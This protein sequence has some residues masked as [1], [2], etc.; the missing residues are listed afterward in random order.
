MPQLL[1]AKVVLT[2]DQAERSEQRGTASKWQ[3]VMSMEV[4]RRGCW[5]S[6]KQAYEGVIE[7]RLLCFYL[8]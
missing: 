4:L 5:D 8:R 7:L 3:Q 6:L 1:L 2:L